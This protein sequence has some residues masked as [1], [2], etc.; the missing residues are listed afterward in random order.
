M[1][2]LTFKCTVFFRPQE[3][4]EIKPLARWGRSTCLKNTPELF[5]CDLKILIHEDVIEFRVVINLADRVLHSTPDHLAGV[6]PAINQPLL[7]VVK[8]RR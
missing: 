7:E 1:R 6:L 2:P 8:R 5:Q 3:D 4:R